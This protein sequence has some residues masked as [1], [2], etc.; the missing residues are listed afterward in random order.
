MRI[1]RK[2][3]FLLSEETKENITWF[4]VAISPITFG[5]LIVCMVAFFITKCYCLNSDEYGF[6]VIPIFFLYFQ[7][8]FD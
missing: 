5:N 7:E 6:I 8:K 1:K 3:G 2:K 4:L